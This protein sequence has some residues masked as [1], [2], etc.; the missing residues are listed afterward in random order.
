M[1]ES[2]MIGAGPA[3]FSST[4]SEI[5]IAIGAEMIKLLLQLPVAMGHNFYQSSVT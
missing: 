4:I 5:V 2:G 3:D 1:A